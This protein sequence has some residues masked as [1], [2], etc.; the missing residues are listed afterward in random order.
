MTPNEL[1]ELKLQIQELLD[2]G[3]YTSKCVPLGSPSDFCE[4]EGRLYA[5]MHGLS[6]A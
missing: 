3:F 2:K 1:K 5:L 4:K 6:I